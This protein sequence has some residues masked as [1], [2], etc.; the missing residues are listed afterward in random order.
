MATRNITTVGRNPLINIST[1]PED[2]W[3]QGGAYTGFP[4]GAPEAVRVVSTSINDTSGGTGARTMTICGLKSNTSKDYEEETLTL[5]GTTNVVSISSWYRIIEAEVITAGS[6]GSNVGTITI[7][8]NVTTA[9]IF[10]TIVPT[11]N[12]A[13]IACFTIP[14]TRTGYMVKFLA[15]LVRTSGAAGSGTVSIR[16]RDTLTANSVFKVIYVFE[17]TT[18]SPFSINMENNSLILKSGSDIKITVESVSDNGT[19]VSA[20]MNI[21]YR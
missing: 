13:A 21:Q 20:L 8:H 10:C 2:V 19:S 4:T 16:V 1:A 17:M 9:N 15:N 3:S 11:Y 5:N 6:T 14:S 12:K 18:G 7:S